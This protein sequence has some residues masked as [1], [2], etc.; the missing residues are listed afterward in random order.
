MMRSASP[1]FCVRSTTPSSRYPCTLHCRACCPAP[2]AM[3]RFRGRAGYA[4]RVALPPGPCFGWRRSKRT[5]GINFV[6]LTCAEL[7]TAGAVDRAEDR[8]HG[9]RRRVG[10][11][12]DPPQDLIACRD[13]DIGGGLG[14]GAFGEGVLGVV[15][16]AD[17]DADRGQGGAERGDRAVAG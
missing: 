7:L 5:F 1:S 10:V 8:A 4:C 13:F 14:V 3:F 9:G 11:D 16:D 6:G 12:A 17:V 15:Q 2:R